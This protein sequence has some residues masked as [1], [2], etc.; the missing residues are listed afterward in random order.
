MEEDKAFKAAME[1]FVES[2]GMDRH[3]RV[4][5][6]VEAAMDGAGFWDQA[7]EL[8]VMKERASYFRS[9]GDWGKVK[10]W[11]A[12]YSAEASRAAKE[13]T[14]RQSELD[15]SYLDKKGED[16]GND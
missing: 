5:M 9:G 12:G 1:A 13:I 6:I 7:R 8:A 15:K 10:A 16:N 2:Q 4:R 3:V 14:A 11:L